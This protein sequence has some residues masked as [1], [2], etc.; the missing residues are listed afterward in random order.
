MAEKNYVGNGW[1]NQ[2]GDIQISVKLEELNKLPVNQYGEVKLFV[3]K[4][5]EVNPKSKATHYV[6]ESKPKEG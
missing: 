3:G 2:Y 4:L 5:R 1:Q 6:C